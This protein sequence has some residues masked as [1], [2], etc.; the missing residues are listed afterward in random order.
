MSKGCFIVFEG[1]DGSG[2]T[3]QAGLLAAALGGRGVRVVLTREPGGTALG[4]GLR[5]LLLYSPGDIDPGAEALLYAAARAQLV[6]QSIRPALAGGA[7]VISDRYAD[8]TLAYQGAGRGLS[9]DFLER[10][11]SFACRG[12]RPDL[13]LLLDLDPALAL[14][15]LG[16]PADRLEGE[17]EGF[18][19]RVRQGYL[20]LAGRDPGRYLVL[21][22][23]LPS[24][25][26]FSRVLTIVERKLGILDS[27]F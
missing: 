18:L 26:L 10:I 22:A 8:S 5:K 17:G 9:G 1:I 24:D 27:G 7:V 13:V 2:K 3:T 21:D 25:L 11:N 16:R 6:A 4:D 15:R 23:T 19:R 12:L 14:S 20:E